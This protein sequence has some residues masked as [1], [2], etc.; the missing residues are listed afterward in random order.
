M[1]SSERFASKMIFFRPCAYRLA[2]SG[3]PFFFLDGVSVDDW[4][5]RFGLLVEGM[6]F[7]GGIRVLFVDYYTWLR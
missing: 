5:T 2:G 7:G 3:L 4:E 6:P 1:V